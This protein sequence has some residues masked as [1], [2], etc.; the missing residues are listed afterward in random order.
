MHILVTGGTGF[1]GSALLDRLLVDGHRLTV[2]SRSVRNGDPRVSYVQSLEA[3]SSDTGI[4]AIINLAG[5]SLAAKRWSEAYKR[6]IVASRLETTEALLALIERLE[7]PPKVL[8]SGSAIG[9]YG[10]HGNE[11]LDEQAKP[12]SG[13]AADLCQRW[14]AVASEAGNAGVRVCLLR[15][16]VVLDRDGGALV[17][18]VRPF[19]MGIANWVGDGKQYLSWIHRDDVVAAIVHLLEQPHLSGPYNLTAPSPVTS[20]Q[21][22]D[23]LKRHLRTLVTL[24]MP[25]VV[26]RTLV[27]EMADELLICGQRVVP[28]G[29]EASGFEF[30]HPDIDSALAAS[31]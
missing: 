7:S 16:G 2:L 4:D 27:G 30:R 11:A 18:M 26:M 14:E 13:F 19:K 12:G 29:L 31:L 3:I 8:L 15:L 25:A 1:I 17:E 21:F 28:G 6:K 9:Y 20:R 5:E 22:C 24:P 23:A 10:A